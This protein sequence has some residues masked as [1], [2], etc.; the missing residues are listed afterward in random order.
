[1]KRVVVSILGGTTARLTGGTP[2]WWSS[3]AHNA[4]AI[5][6]G[7]SLQQIAY[8]A[9]VRWLSIRKARVFPSEVPQ[10]RLLQLYSL[11]YI[12]QCAIVLLAAVYL[13]F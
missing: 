5:H 1:M 6:S 3:M 7:N 13:S 10:P 12:R 8:I 11:S 4:S 2:F 9:E